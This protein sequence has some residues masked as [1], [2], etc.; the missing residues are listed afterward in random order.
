MLSNVRQRAH[1]SIRPV[2]VALHGNHFVIRA[3]RF[4]YEAFKH[5]SKSLS[6]GLKCFGFETR[7]E[8]KM[9]HWMQTAGLHVGEKI[10]FTLTD[11]S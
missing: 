3:M 4:W 7:N 5:C 1:N 11:E 2:F 6:S 8:N 10:L 9:M